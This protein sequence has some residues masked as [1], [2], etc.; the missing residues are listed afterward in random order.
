MTLKEKIQA[1]LPINGTHINTTDPMF[2][3]I[4]SYLGYDFIWVDCEHTHMDFEDVYHHINAARA[5]G[6]PVIVRVPV[7]DLTFT[8]KVIEMGVDGIV[9]PMVK[10]AEHAKELL[11]WTLYP[12]YGKRGCGPKGATR[13]GIDNEI[14]YFKKGQFNL[15]RLVQIELESAALDAENIAA[16]PYLDGCVLGMFDLSGSINDPGNIF[17]EENLRLANRSIRAFR[18][19]GKTVGVSTF[20]TQASTVARYVDMGI[21]MISSG[22]D[23]CYMIEG[24]RNTLSTLQKAREN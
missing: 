23:Y 5:G 22:A 8:K 4:A 12:P 1:C 19:A 7:S 11:S 21:N 3:E 10:D 16:I 15:I 2:T 24:A 20:D 14:E 9:F 17:S 18:D 6:T 13:Y